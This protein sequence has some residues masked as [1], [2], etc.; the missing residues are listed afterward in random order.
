MLDAAKL[1]HWFPG[2]GDPFKLPVDIFDG[3]LNEIVPIENWLRGT[4]DSPQAQAEAFIEA[5]EAKRNRRRRR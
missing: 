3:Y 1:R 2:L 5:L 4:G